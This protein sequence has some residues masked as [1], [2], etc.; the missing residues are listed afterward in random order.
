MRVLFL[1]LCVGVFSASGEMRN[2][3]SYGRGHDAVDARLSTDSPEARV[4][5]GVQKSF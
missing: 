2:E 3:V 5:L 1:I 4:T